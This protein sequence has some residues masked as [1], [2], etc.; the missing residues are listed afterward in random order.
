MAL[1]ASATPSVATDIINILQ[2]EN[3]AKVT[4]SFNRPNLFY[5]VRQ[6]PKD[7]VREIANWLNTHHRGKTGIIYRSSR[8]GTE[9]MAKKLKFEHQIEAKHFHA[10][11]DERNKTETQQAWQEGR[12][13]VVVATVCFDSCVVC[14]VGLYSTTKIAFGMGIDKPDGMLF[15]RNEGQLTHIYVLRNPLRHT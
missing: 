4:D 11:K 6:R 2:M 13:K 14:L 7:S 9:I 10:G 5:E 3:T 8:E 15:L 12:L 1:T